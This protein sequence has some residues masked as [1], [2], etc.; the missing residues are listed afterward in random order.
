MPGSQTIDTGIAGFDIRRLYAII[1]QTRGEIL[2]ATGVAGKGF[3]AV[4]GSVIT[5]QA[6]TSTHLATDAVQ[7]IYDDPEDTDLTA[8]LYELID[9][10]AF[11]ANVR[12]TIADLRVSVVGGALP[13]V[14]TLS[15]IGSIGGFAANQHI[16]ATQNVAALSNINNLIIS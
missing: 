8:G 5:L 12:G 9:R 2:Y 3:S 1:N 11:L 10:L 14:S 13:T 15:N 4:S 6:N 16:P 7:L